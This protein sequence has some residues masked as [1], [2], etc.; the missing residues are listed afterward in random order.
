MGLA[1]MVV[2]CGR[3]GQFELNVMIPLIAHA[4]HESITCLANGC[5]VFARQCVGGHRGRCRPAA[6]NW[7]IAR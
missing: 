5:R 7:W 3:D 6:G 1:N 4:L 2:L